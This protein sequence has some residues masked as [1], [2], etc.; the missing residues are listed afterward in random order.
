MVKAIKAYKRAYPLFE[1]N[2][3]VQYWIIKRI[4][5]M[6]IELSTGIKL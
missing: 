4:N 6:E 3:D 5:A 2:P 1:D